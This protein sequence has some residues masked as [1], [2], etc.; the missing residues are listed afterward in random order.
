MR[1]KR[2]VL[3]LV[4]SAAAAAAVFAVRGRHDSSR[5]PQ[6]RPASPGRLDDAD[7][8]RRLQRRGLLTTTAR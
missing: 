7:L 4:L 1:R 8:M 3:V 2:V 5:A 6:L